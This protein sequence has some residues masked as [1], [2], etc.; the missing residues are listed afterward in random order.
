MPGALPVL[1]PRLPGDHDVAG[2]P[3]SPS[4][5]PAVIMPGIIAPVMAQMT[6][7]AFRS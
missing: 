4:W 7:P 2:E 6:A 1:S 5:W 3:G